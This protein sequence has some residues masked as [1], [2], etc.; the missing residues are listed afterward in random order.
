MNEF[1]QKGGITDKDF[2]IHVL[3]N[4]P[5]VYNVILNGL[6]NCLIATGDDML[7]IDVIHKN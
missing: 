7:T 2:M 4:L 6:E 5:K 3:N 1:G